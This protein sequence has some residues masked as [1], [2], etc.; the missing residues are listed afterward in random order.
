LGSGTLG[1]P[2]L[3]VKTAPG[4]GRLIINKTLN[5]VY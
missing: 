4:L 5:L 3:D 2:Q 1:V